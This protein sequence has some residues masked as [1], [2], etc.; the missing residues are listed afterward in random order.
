MKFN[1][2]KIDLTKNIYIRINNEKD[3]RNFLNYLYNKHKAIYNWFSPGRTEYKSKY[4]YINIEFQECELYRVR[5]NLNRQVFYI[6]D[7]DKLFL[8][9]KKLEEALKPNN[10]EVQ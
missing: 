2:T 7:L 5:F 3:Y 1:N 9:F 6:E 8:S 4:K 10:Y